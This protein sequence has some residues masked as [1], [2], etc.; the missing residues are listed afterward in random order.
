MVMIGVCKGTQ[1][2]WKDLLKAKSVM[3]NL[4]E[5]NYNPKYK[6]HI[7]ESILTYIHD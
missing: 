3:T 4:Q 5:N 7:H 2:Q 1:E 6:I